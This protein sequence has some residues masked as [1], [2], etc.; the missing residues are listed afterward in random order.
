MGTVRQC[1]FTR[2][3]QILQEVGILVSKCFII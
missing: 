2:R 3:V 1:T